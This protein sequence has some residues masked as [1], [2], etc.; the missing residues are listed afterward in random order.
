MSHVVAMSPSVVADSV[1]AKYCGKVVDA[2][3]DAW[4]RRVIVGVLMFFVTVRISLR[5]GIPSVTFLLAT[6][7]V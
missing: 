2:P 5:R 7:A 4:K 3:R 6:P 1:L